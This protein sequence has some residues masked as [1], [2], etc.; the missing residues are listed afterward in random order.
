[1]WSFDDDWVRVGCGVGVG[2]GSAPVH[3]SWYSVYVVHWFGSF[4]LTTVTQRGGAVIWL[5]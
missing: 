5:P 1:M 3:V 4:P 2:A